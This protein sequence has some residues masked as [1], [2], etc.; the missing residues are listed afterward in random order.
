MQVFIMSLLAKFQLGRFFD[1]SGQPQQPSYDGP[2]C[3]HVW[4]DTQSQSV[5]STEEVTQ[6]HNVQE[7]LDKYKAYHDC[8]VAKFDE[9]VRQYQRRKYMSGQDTAQ[10]K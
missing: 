1:V 7:Q 4:Q 2:D 8:K 6:E 9:S 5:D 3:T 10:A